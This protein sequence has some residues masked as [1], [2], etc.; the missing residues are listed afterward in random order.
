MNL[1]YGKSCIL[2][3]LQ[4][5]LKASVFVF[6]DFIHL[7]LNTIHLLNIQ[8]SPDF[9]E[10]DA[11]VE[12]IL[13]FLD[14]KIEKDIFD[15]LLGNSVRVFKRGK[16]AFEPIQVAVGAGI[17]KK[18]LLEIENDRKAGRLNSPS[19]IPQCRFKK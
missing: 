12:K 17:S 3:Q 1:K 8:E 10:E 6:H 5:L 19:S 14:M 13:T 2:H 15:F 11:D 9:I 4:S 18:I 7:I 16:S